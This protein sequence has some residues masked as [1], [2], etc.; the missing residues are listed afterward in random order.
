MVDDKQIPIFIIARDRLEC[1]RKLITALE[2]RDYKHIHIIDNA[3]TYE[4]LLE[5]YTT[6]PY[7]IH[8]NTKNYGHEVIMT[9]NIVDPYMHDFYAYTDCDVIPVE[10]CPDDFLTFFK[11]L[12]NRHTSV[13]KAGFGLKIDDLPEHYRH[14]NSVIEWEKQYWVNEAEQ[15]VYHAPIDTT[16]ALVRPGKKIVWAHALR[17]NFPYIARHDA[18]YTD[19]ANMPEDEKYYRAHAN[20]S[21]SWG[22]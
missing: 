3:S 5:Y 10:E 2:V 9:T 19:S 14:K 12:L 6:L 7:T 22:A 13:N 4:P 20:S 16:F 11:N 17:T 21:A 15:G 1:L 8:R 18:W